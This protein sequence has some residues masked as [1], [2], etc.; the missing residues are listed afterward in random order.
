VAE[1]A[2]YTGAAQLARLPALE[3]EEERIEKKA[4]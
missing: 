2:V 1:T 3:K 4:K